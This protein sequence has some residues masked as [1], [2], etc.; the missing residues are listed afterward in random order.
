M[1]Q[2][3]FLSMY[4]AEGVFHFILFFYLVIYFGDWGHV[5]LKVDGCQ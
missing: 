1:C 5:D 2:I 4:Y 3:I